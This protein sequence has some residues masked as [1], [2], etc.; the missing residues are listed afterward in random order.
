[1]VT[2]RLPTY[3]RREEPLRG[4]VFRVWSIFAS[5]VRRGFR[6]ILVI[7]V[8]LVALAWGVIST[9][10]FI[11]LSD[12][13]SEVTGQPITL[14]NFFVTIANPIMLIFILLVA[15]VV[16]A[17]LIADDLRHRSLTLYLSRPVTTLGYLVAK[18]SVVGL[19]LFIAIAFPGILSPIVA[20]LLL[21]V[22]WE[23]ALAA[24][25]AGLAFGLLALAVF[26]LLA[27]MFSSLTDRK[28][29][30]AAATFG[31][32][33]GSS[34]LAMPLQDLFKADEFLHI[35]L[36]ENLLAVARPLYAVEQVGIAWDVA[37]AILIGVMAVAG[38]VTFLRMR[39][40]EVVSG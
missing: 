3:V 2:L 35:S 14:F 1:M 38:A 18:V 40:I 25:G 7:L 6:R 22:S 8:L 13:V 32:G 16:G 21:Y 23:T 27:L 15:A 30:A 36:Y 26:S 17:G 4:Q 37:L 29:I 34:T 9:I 11:F 28:G 31:V 12:L 39:T 10:L 33:F 20:A 19:A 5:G 24:L